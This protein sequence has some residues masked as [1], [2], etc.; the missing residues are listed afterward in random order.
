MD[1]RHEAAGETSEKPKVLF[2]LN[3]YYGPFYDD[4]DNTGVNVVDL[5][6]AF[7]V[8]EENGFDIVIASDTGD[9][10][11]DDKSFRDPAIVD[12]TQSIF[13]NP[14]CSL[15]K[16]LK[17]IA[18]LDRLNPSDYVIVYIPGGYGCS[19]DFPHAKVVQDFLYRFYETK[20]I[21]CA[22]AQANIA[23]AYTTNSDGQALCTNRRVT[24]CTW[25]DEVQNGVLNVMNRLNFYSFGHIAENIGAIF[26]SPPVYVEDPFIVEDGQLFTGS[27]TNSAKGVAMEAVRAVLNYDG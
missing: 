2:L 19:F 20:G 25:K 21:I 26:E 18:R 24:G 3:S 13:S 11:F 27:N 10:G 9:Y 8:F 14:D 6:E 17:N 12:E 22:V 15:M 7:K 16:K 4:G 1:E 5:Y 23:L